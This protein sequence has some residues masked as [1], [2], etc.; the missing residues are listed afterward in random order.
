MDRAVKI[1]VLGAGGFGTA[2]AQSIAPSVTAVTL[3]ARSPDVVESVNRRHRNRYYLPDVPLR[4][5]V[6]A[7]DFAGAEA[8]LRDADVITFCVPSSVTRDVARDVADSVAGKIVLSTAKG[9]A[10]P[11]LETMS[12]VITAESSPAEIVTLSGPTFADEL[13]RGFTSYATLGGDGSTARKLAE[14]MFGESNLH[15]D[16]CADRRGVEYCGILKNVFSIA[17]GI[18]DAFAQ[19][20]NTH[21]GFL[22]YCYKEMCRFL[23]VLCTDVSISQKFCAFGDF[24]LTASVDKSRNRTLGMMIGKNF[25]E[26]DQVKSGIIFEGS[27]SIHAIHKIAQDNGLKAPITDVVN[28]IFTGETDTPLEYRVMQLLKQLGDA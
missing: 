21:F 7:H 22:N 19:S 3:V 18:I 28:G 5:N 24:T 20:N 14:E 15:M 6:R 9:I 27:K 4:E 13:V 12:E 23:A 25:I 8:V 11:S 1:A 2:M 26:V 10:F 17:V 16:F